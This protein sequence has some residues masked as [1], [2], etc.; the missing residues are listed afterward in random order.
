[1]TPE[2][3]GNYVFG[4]VELTRK[5][6]R[7]RFRQSI[8]DEWGCC[9]YCGDK[10]NYL[11]IDHVKPR[12]HGGDSMR[13]NLVP[14]C[15]TCNANKGSSRDWQSWYKSQ[16]F[17]CVQR[18]SRIESWTKPRLTEDLDLWLIAK[19][20]R[21]ADR[22]EPRATVYSQQNFDRDTALQQRGAYCGITRLLGGE[23]QAE[24]SF[25]G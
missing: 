17:F 7:K 2:H 4:L 14:A 1:M 3:W 10:P 8:K 11:T 19:G 9:A 18:A 13:N 6:A 24:G 23:V 25:S 20:G 21:H 15:R 22:F 16:S 5:A 12:I